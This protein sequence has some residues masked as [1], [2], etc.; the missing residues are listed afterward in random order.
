MQKIFKDLSFHEI[1]QDEDIMIGMYGTVE[2]ANAF[3]AIARPGYT[4]HDNGNELFSDNDNHDSNFNSF[5]AEPWNLYQYYISFH[6]PCYFI[7][8]PSYTSM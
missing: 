4:S 6:V 3:V 5:V 1:V 2:Q 7:F 8:I